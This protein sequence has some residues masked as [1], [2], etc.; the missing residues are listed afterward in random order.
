MR[1]ITLAAALCA[2]VATGAVA[3]PAL[4]GD[5]TEA[6]ADRIVYVCDSSEL[7]RASFEREFGEQKFVTAEE[8]IEAAR[9]RDVWAAPVCMSP[10][11]YN[12]LATYMEDR[13]QSVVLTARSSD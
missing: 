3:A 11:E 2:A 9:Q 10:A 1:T 12:K 5:T 7:T 6:K 4:A 13:G 8:A